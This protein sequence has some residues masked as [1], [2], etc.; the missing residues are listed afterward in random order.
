MDPMMPFLADE[1]ARQLRHDADLVRA[2]RGERRGLRRYLPHRR[3]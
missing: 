3:S 1:R 2:G